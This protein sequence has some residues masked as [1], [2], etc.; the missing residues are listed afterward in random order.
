[1]SI[2]HDKIALDES[3]RHRDTNGYLHVANSHISKETVSPYYGSEIADAE[4]VGVKLDPDTIYYGYRAGEELDKA[5][6]TFNGLPLLFEHY[7]DSAENPQKEHRV[8]SLGTDAAYSAPYLDNSLII[9]AANAI[10]A[11]ES[12]DYKELSSAYRYTPDFTP[13]EFNGQKYDFV[14]RDIVGN[15]V[16]LVQEGRAGRDV[17]VADSQIK[18]KGEETGMDKTKELVK[19]LMELLTGYQVN[20]VHPE[21]EG[22][23]IVVKG[24]G[25]DEHKEEHVEDEGNEIVMDDLIEAISAVEDPELLAKI[26]ELLGATAS[27]ELDVEYAGVTKG[28]EDGKGQK[29]T[30]PAMD[31]NAIKKAVEKTMR[32]KHEA[33]KDCSP[34]CGEIVDPYAFDSANDIYK[35]A[36]EVVGVDVSKYSPSAY[37]GMV[38]ML[39]GANAVNAFH[40][41]ADGKAKRGDGVDDKYFA[42]LDNIRVIG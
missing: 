4:G 23:E 5:A 21:E 22:G 11:I 2:L 39:K 3:A 28:A 13:G 30:A 26:K 16:A 14:M 31:A 20:D 34:L 42:G 41:A 12:G 17:A 37:R 25:E 6:A 40:S 9:T 10:A 7:F 24:E 18:N 35:Q 36:L 1:M 27:D 29:K 15:H 19:R 32:E 8:G 33:A 38:D